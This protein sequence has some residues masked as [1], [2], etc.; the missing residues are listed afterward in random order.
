MK[1]VL[2][3]CIEKEKTGII[4]FENKGRVIY[5]GHF[6]IDDKFRGKGISTRFMQQFFRIANE[7]SNKIFQMWVEDGNDIAINLY[8]NIGFK[9]TNKNTLS[10]IKK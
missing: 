6:A 7:N 4:R 1:R 2:I 3:A 8:K 9:Y 5:W 10:L